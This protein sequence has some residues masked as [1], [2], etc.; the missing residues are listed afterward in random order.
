MTK[1]KT[2][3]SRRDKAMVFIALVI[4]FN[5]ISFLESVKLS[6]YC[7]S[8][9]PFGARTYYLPYDF[10]CEQAEWLYSGPR[11]PDTVSSGIYTG[12]GIAS[13][14]IINLSANPTSDTGRGVS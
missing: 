14:G 9:E 12:E 13:T 8:P 4:C 6:E 3:K 11:V 7:D 5:A 2:N 10:D 1:N